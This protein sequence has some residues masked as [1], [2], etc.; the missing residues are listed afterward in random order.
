MMSVSSLFSITITIARETLERGR[1]EIAWTLR[2]GPGR[3]LAH[4]VTTSRAAIESRTALRR[5]ATDPP[6]DES[7]A[8]ARRWGERKRFARAAALDRGGALKRVGLA[9]VRT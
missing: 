3:V 7:R 9:P 8:P 5:L 2:E 6:P 1:R 4:P